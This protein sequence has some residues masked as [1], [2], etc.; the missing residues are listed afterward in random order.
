MFWMKKSGRLQQRI[1]TTGDLAEAVAVNRSVISD[2]LARGII[3]APQAPGRGHSRRFS[4][5]NAVQAWIARDLNRMGIRAGAIKTIFA[6]ADVEFFQLNTA[7]LGNG[8][9][10]RG[11]DDC[12]LLIGFGS[13]GDVSWVRR[14][15]TALRTQAPADLDD[16]VVVLR[17]DVN[18]AMR[19]VADAL[20]Q[21]LPQIQR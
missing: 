6:V 5:W 4:F 11:Q 15:S 13:D 18:A 19:H 14:E 20:H 16:A 12:V 17:I 7:L 10:D 9:Q 21:R 3:A 8:G 1:L 2:W